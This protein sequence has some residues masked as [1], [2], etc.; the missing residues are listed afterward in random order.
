MILVAYCSVSRKHVAQGLFSTNT[1]PL[2]MCRENM[3]PQLSL[4]GLQCHSTSYMDESA[5]DAATSQHTLGSQI[6]TLNVLVHTTVVICVPKFREWL[7]DKVCPQEDES[8]NTRSDQVFCFLAHGPTQHQIHGPFRSSRPFL[9]S[10]S[11]WASRA[12]QKVIMWLCVIYI[13]N[14]YIYIH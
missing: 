4:Q 11:R 14:Y 1:A 8:A 6:Y 7:K 9:E 12:P 10:S 2:N 5:V 13:Y 3:K